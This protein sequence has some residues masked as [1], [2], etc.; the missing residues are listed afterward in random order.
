MNM[1]K[2]ASLFSAFAVDSRKVVPG[3]LF[4]ALKG[5]KTDGHNFLREAAQRGAWAAVVE[6]SCQKESFG[7]EL[8]R[9]DNV[10]ENL[11]SRAREA[12]Q[13]R[14]KK[15]PLTV[16]GI[17]GSVGKTTTKEFAATL[18]K[19]KYRVAK[20]EKN[21]N[22]QIGLPLAILNLDLA[23]AEV[24]VLEMG[25]SRMGE[26]EKLVQIAAP[27]IG[28]ITKIALAHAAYFKSRRAI[29][30]EKSR[31]F[32]GTKIRIFNRELFG[33]F[34]PGGKGENSVTFSLQDRKADYFLKKRPGG[35][36]V[37]ERG[38]GFF[39]GGLF[40]ENHLL[41]DFLAALALARALEVEMATL[42]KM[43]KN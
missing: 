3:A 11:H 26:M 33:K 10:L 17:T 13:E 38:K 40:E 15:G 6:K 14:K 39:F 20:T 24:L 30:E 27:E 35:F 22:S 1:L 12:V 18:L 29:F 28:L 2:P 9:V 31:I 37:L 23:E 5:E 41:E 7:L 34:F 19:G 21:Q 42:Q 8:L 43:A 25:I 16:L 4:F 36:E 32:E